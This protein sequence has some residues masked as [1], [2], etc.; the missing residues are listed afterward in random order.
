MPSE[1]PGRSRRPDPALNLIDSALHDG[2][3][4]LDAYGRFATGLIGAVLFPYAMLPPQD[5]RGETAA[6]KAAHR[7]SRQHGIV[8]VVLALLIGAVIGRRLS[9]RRNASPRGIRINRRSDS[10]L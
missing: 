10:P 5:P 6:E 3:V 2:A 1:R 8:N 4:I 7:Q 9:A